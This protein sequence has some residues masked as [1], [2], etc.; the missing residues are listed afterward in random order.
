MHF[1]LSKGDLT[2]Q[3]SSYSYPVDI[4]V[5]SVSRWMVFKR[6]LGTVN[7]VKVYTGPLVDL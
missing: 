2:R 7:D 6:L 3:D 4:R 5:D 1:K